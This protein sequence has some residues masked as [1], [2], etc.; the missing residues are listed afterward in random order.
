MIL[1]DQLLSSHESATRCYPIILCNAFYHPLSSYAILGPRRN[2]TL[3]SYLCSVL[4]YRMLLPGFGDCSTGKKANDGA[5]TVHGQYAPARIAMPMICTDTGVLS[6]PLL[7]LPSA[8]VYLSVRRLY[9]H[10]P[11]RTFLIPTVCTDLTLLWY[12]MK[13]SGTHRWY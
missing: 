7:V 13:L 9:C 10:V 1:S 5:Q 8:Y 12:E 3:S 6:L 4:T 2:F 11:T